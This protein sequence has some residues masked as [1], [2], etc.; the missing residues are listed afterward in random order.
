MIDPDPSGDNKDYYEIQINPQN[1]VFDSQFDDYN[2]PRQEPDGPFGHQDWSAKLESAVQIRGTLNDDKDKDDGYAVEVRIPWSSFDKVKDLPPAPGSLW[3]MNLYAMQN[4]DG[5]AWS[6]ILEQGNFHK[7][8]RFGR[9]SFVLEPTPVAGSDG[10]TATEHAPGRSAP[11][12]LSVTR[13]ALQQAPS[14]APKAPPTAPAAV[15]TPAPAAPIPEPPPTVP[16]AP[17]APS[18]E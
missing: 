14:P 15:T 1:L 13:K 5:V 4:N 12:G 7:A 16:A 11:P 9:V 17:P 2:Q 10:H 3:R 6:P 8:S 18:G